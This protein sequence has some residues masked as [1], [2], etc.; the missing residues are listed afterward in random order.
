MT[1]RTAPAASA[2]ADAETALAQLGFSRIPRVHLNLSVARLYEEAL[3]RGEAMLAADGPLVAH[4]GAHTGRSANDRFIVKSGD[5]ERLVAWGQ[6]NKPLSPDYFARLKKKVIAHLSE[7]GE[8]FVQDCSVGADPAHRL[9]VRVVTERAWHSLFAK[10]MFLPAQPSEAPFTILHA[11]GCKADPLT[12][13]TRSSTFVVLDFDTRLVLIGGTE[14]AGEIKKSMFSVMNYVLPQREVMSMHCSANVGQ[15]GD[16][17]VFFGLSGTGKTTL[18]AD[19]DRSL[20]GDDEHGWSS[21]GV[22]NIEGGCY[23]KVIRLS[24]EAEPEIYSTTRRFG[25][26]LE[27]VAIDPHTRQL[28]LDS[29]KY[30]EN[31]RAS[32][33]LDKIPNTILSGQAGT[34]RSIV[35]LTCDAFGVLPPIARLSPEQAM[36]HFLSGYTAKVAGTEIGVTEPKATFST[37]FGA[38][39]MPLHPGVY[40][41]LLGERMAKAG[42]RAWLVN[43]GWTGGSFGTGKRMKISFT[44]AMVRAA[45][46]GALD[47][48]K[49]EKDPVFGFEVPAAVPGVPSELLRP[50]ETWADPAA[51]DAQQRKVAR[52]FVDNFE[53]Y[54]SGVAAEIVAAAPRG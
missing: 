17:A 5:A 29:D 42:A 3:R 40:T 43:T 7:R 21:S 32:Y 38:P 10:N 51:Y 18:S 44:R 50:R 37:C 24:R 23:A 28:D 45:L 12:D 33:T 34:P 25:T 8:V 14:Y 11:P 53:Q 19:P 13:G 20:V 6:V 22:F 49:F 16:V 30:T 1:I 26:V 31:T 54:K 52:M 15:N 27:N 4:T 46:A 41:K 9:P 36:Y 48:S 39:F 47:E 2:S 35:F